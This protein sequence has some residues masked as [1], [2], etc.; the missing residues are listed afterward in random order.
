M[1]RVAAAAACV[2]TFARPSSA[3][4]ALDT[5]KSGLTL[6]VGSTVSVTW[7][8]TILH[9]GIGYDLDLVDAD[10]MIQ[11]SIASGLSTSVHSFDWVV[12]D[13]WCVGCYLMVTQLNRAEHDYSDSVL[14]N[15]YGKPAMMASGGSGGSQNATGGHGGATSVAG[16][17]GAGKQS[18]AG[19]GGTLDTGTL[20]E[21]SAGSV[22]SAGS[23][24]VPEIPASG[25][26][27]GAR[28][29]GGKGG[30]HM[31][32]AAGASASSVGGSS[33]AGDGTIDA[34]DD[35]AGEASFAPSDSGGCSFDPS[36]SSPSRF[37]LLLALFS[38][39]SSRRRRRSLG[40]K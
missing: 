6:A 8:D 28:S 2:W 22:S 14:I 1:T 27:A 40:R 20:P 17:G 35:S 32:A 7:E 26:A 13:V 10:A 3:H 9:D 39:A 12:P 11:A 24:V 30:S 18:G 33:A 21:S 38:F 31:N 19:V 34:P 36:R 4:V 15:I 23:L 25:A 16:S 29:S 37:A 5:P